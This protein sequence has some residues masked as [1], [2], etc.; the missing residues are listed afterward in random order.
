MTYFPNQDRKVRLGRPPR[1]PWD[2]WSDGRERVL[3]EGQ[4]FLCMAESF[5]LLCRRTARIRSMQVTVS[6]TTVPENGPPLSVEIDGSQQYLQPGDTYVLVK[7][8]KE[9]ETE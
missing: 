3:R 6:T 4:D 2:E 8:T 7:F 5:V 9:K 1:Y